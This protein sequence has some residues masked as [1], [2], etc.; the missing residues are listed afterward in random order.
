MHNRQASNP[1][2]VAANNHEAVWERIVD[3]LHD[4]QFRIASEN[5]LDGRIE[6]DYKT[7]ASF[8]EPWHRDSVGVENKWESTLQP[9]RRKVI[10]SITPADGGYLVA[11]EAL[12]E[13]EDLNGLAANSAGGA[14]FQESTPLVR[15]LD[16][17]V[18]QTAPS[19]WV[20]LGRDLYLEQSLAQSLQVAFSR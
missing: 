17:V 14:T 1:V 5:K 9:I 13:L 3:V 2:Y 12:K 6:T 18:G 11:V 4:Y 15:D 19:Q 8:L 20:F 7:G 10:V 16:Q